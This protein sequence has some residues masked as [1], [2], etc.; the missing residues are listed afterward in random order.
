MPFDS[1]TD[2]VE[3][4]SH[5][6][7]KRILPTTFDTAAM[8][9]I[10]ASIRRQSFWSA[11][12]NL[13]DILT[14]EKEKILSILHPT[15]E[16]REGQEQ[17]VTVGFNPAYA[18]QAIKEHFRA[19]GYQP[20]KGLR[21]TIQDL[22]SDNRINLVIDTNVKLAHGAGHFIQAN[23]DPDVV[24]QW[25]GW[26]FIR[27]G[28][29]KEPRRW[30]GINGLWVNACR[31][32]SDDA[33]IACY[34]KT[35]RMCALKSSG[36]WGEVSDPDY[37]PGGLGELYDPVAFG[38]GMVREEMSREECEEAELLKPGQKAEPARF[39]LADLF[40]TPES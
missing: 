40:R 33:A 22:S 32:A 39:D 27:A 18:R 28:E 10:D 12:N 31:R 16:T 13:V 29:R 11:Q 15:Q 20:G 30:E 24:D 36:V 1:T 21:G 9:Q 5:F 14:D 26:E 37:T 7:S 38:T 19:M 6:V 35:G 23:A 17:T 34:A 3:A 4:L 8:R 2:F 25:P